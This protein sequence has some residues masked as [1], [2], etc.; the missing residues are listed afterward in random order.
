[1]WRST[2]CRSPERPV[3]EPQV[4]PGG[5]VWIPLDTGLARMQQAQSVRRFPMTAPVDQVALGGSGPFVLSGGDALV[6]QRLGEP[7]CSTVRPKRSW[8]TA[9]RSSPWTAQGAGRGFR[10]ETPRARFRSEPTSPCIRAGQGGLVRGRALLPLESGEVALLDLTQ[11]EAPPAA[12]RA[13][14]ERTAHAL[15]LLRGLFPDPRDEPLG[16]RPVSWTIPSWRLALPA[17]PGRLPRWV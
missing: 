8:P 10:P 9:W 7:H 4:A 13:R 17:L 1:M 6:L 12:P 3:G 16:Q 2:A 14:P 11:P 5:V 15:C